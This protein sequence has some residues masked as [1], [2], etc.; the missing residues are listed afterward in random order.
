MAD[1][2]NS[3]LVNNVNLAPAPVLHRGPGRPIGRFTD[4]SSN[5]IS[6][7]IY[8]GPVHAPAGPAFGAFPGTQFF[9]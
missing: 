5:T 7:P 9:S 2:L 3:F 4:G 6:L 8:R 1:F